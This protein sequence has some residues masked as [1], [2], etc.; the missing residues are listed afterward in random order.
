MNHSR[1]LALFFGAIL[2]LAAAIFASTEGASS[3]FEPARLD[4]PQ[5]LT[6][7]GPPV[8][9]TLTIN[10]VGNGSVT[11]NPNNTQ[12]LS[13]TV[14]ALTAV[15]NAGATFVSWSGDLSGSTNPQNI[16]MSSN[17]VVTATFT[18]AVCYTLNT[19][20]IPSNAGSVN[21]SPGP[22]CS[23]KYG[24]GTTID[25]TATPN[26]GF[27]FSSWSGISGSTN[28][29]S[30]V[31]SSNTSVTATFVPCFTLTTNVSPGGSGSVTVNTA[32]NCG[33][34]YKQGTVVSLTASPHSGYTFSSWNGATGST[35]A[36]TVTMN[37]NTT[38]TANFS[39]IP[40]PPPSATT[41][42]ATATSTTQPGA[43]NTPIPQATITP[44]LGVAIASATATL[45]PTPTSNLPT[46]GGS[47]LTL[48]A[49]GLVLVMIVIGS[50]YMRQSST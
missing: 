34:Q 30:F 32:A 24:S 23:G 4:V 49:I 37:G 26:S 10:I 12:Y 39:L 19:S 36:G 21:A 47:P 15:P 16:T 2:F 3:A 46:T 11:K 40:P 44:L 48:V 42:S 38:V 1:K 5:V 8:S 35:A 29:A 27:A 45:T 20:V 6:L 22:N 13:G 31:I 7:Q 17:K 33:T 28:I 41:T 18:T 14:V 50:R 43:T 9:A 25:L